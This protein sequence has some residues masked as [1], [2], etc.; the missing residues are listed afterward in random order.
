MD[1]DKFAR[2]VFQRL[3]DPAGTSLEPMT[4]EEVRQLTEGD[5]AALRDAEPSAWLAMVEALAGVYQQSADSRKQV[6]EAYQQRLSTGRE[7]P[8]VAQSLRYHIE[9]NNA[10][11]A[12]IEALLSRDVDRLRN[13]IEQHPE[14][15]R[16]LRTQH[17][18]YDNATHPAAVYY[19][20][21]VIN[22]LF[23]WETLTSG[24]KHAPR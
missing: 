19:R 6:N 23:G 12:C 16:Y 4:N 7:A 14:Q 18:Y 10:A 3:T 15:W 1:A 17:H 5:V 11:I 20:N 8:G 2:N 13:A 9:Q 21:R 24:G 22:P